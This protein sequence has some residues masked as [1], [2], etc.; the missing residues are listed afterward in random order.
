L[1]NE[2][3]NTQTSRL[4]LAG[5]R[6]ECLNGAECLVDPELHD[7]PD[8]LTTI[9][10]PDARAARE[11]VARE[12]CRTCPVRGACL[13]YAIRVRPDRGVWAGYTTA[14]IPR[15]TTRTS[16]EEVA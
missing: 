7:G 3:M 9:E 2:P 13:T 16:M 6:D 8:P 1:E 5:L 14:E 10:H 15:T 4:P 12:V 11:D